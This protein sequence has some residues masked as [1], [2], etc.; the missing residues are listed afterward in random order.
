MIN[1]DEIYELAS[2]FEQVGAAASEAE[3]AAL[4]TEAPV[5]SRAAKFFRLVTQM[6][7]KDIPTECREIG[8]FRFFVVNGLVQAQR[9]RHEFQMFA[10]R[11]IAVGLREFA[12]YF[13][14][15]DSK[16]TRT[17]Y[18]DLAQDQKRFFAFCIAQLIELGFGIGE[19]LLTM[20]GDASDQGDAL[21]LRRLREEGP[22]AFA[23]SWLFDEREKEL[24]HAVFAD[25]GPDATTALQRYFV[26]T[27]GVP[28]VPAPAA[29]PDA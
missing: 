20:K 19:L 28:F 17:A 13:A 11:A 8:F 27:Y 21:E 15:L 2:V 7:D 25:R 24:W 10:L 5:D 22:D 18:P 9:L 29:T 14:Y 3:L 23:V 1:P 4:A 26:Q 12:T 16:S 6:E